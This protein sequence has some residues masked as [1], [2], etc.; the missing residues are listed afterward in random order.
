MFQSDINSPGQQQGSPLGGTQLAGGCHD[1][2][3]GDGSS[4]VQ[5]T[6]PMDDPAWPYDAEDL[7]VHTSI[8]FEIMC[9][10]HFN[11]VLCALLM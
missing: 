8:Y 7:E 9:I 2:I 4:A 5:G 3:A 6:G 11:R 10:T 1:D